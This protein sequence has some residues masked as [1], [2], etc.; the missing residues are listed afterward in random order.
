MTSLLL[1]ADMGESFGPW[2][3]G[4]DHEVMPHVDLANIACGFHASDPD[5]MRRTVRMAAEHSVGVGAHPAYPDLVGFGRRS[6][7]CSPAEIENLV[8]YQVGALAAMCRA[9]GTAIRYVK[10]HGALYNDMARKPEIFTAVARA[11]LAYDPELPLMTLATRD[12]SAIRELAGE[13]RITLW[14][15]AFADRAY[16]GDGRLVSRSQAGAVHHAPDVIL[17]QA[18]RIATGQPLTASNGSDL[19][20]TADTLCVHGDNEESVASVRAIRQM[21]NTLGPQR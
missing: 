7:A 18:Q 21:L 1:N 6:M 3:M 9:E 14:F 16:D 2:V 5:V 11:I 19:V 15:E 17:D 20:L 10:P 12:T 8:L 4:L 13:H